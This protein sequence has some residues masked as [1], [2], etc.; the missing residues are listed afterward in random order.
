ML[1][2]INGLAS[3]DEGSI[4]LAGITMTDSA[5]QAKLITHSVGMVFRNFNLFPH[6]TALENV[7]SA[8]ELV[9]HLSQS[10]CQALSK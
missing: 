9:N 3:Y 2:R 8:P 7:M 5:S 4:K 6:L 1:R 10:A